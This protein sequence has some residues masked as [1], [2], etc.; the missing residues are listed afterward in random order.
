MASVG[1]PYRGCAVVRR[2]VFHWHACTARP[3]FSIPSRN[4]GEIL[5]ELRLIGAC[6]VTWAAELS[7]ERHGRPS[8]GQAMLSQVRLA[9]PGCRKGYRRPARSRPP[10]GR[11]KGR[12][13]REM[14]RA[15]QA[16][17]EIGFVVARDRL[18]AAEDES[19]G[20]CVLLAEPHGQHLV[21]AHAPTEHATLL[22]ACAAGEDIPRLPRVNANARGILVEETRDHGSASPLEQ[23][24][25]A[26]S[27][28]SSSTPP[29]RQPLAH[30]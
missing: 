1:R 7:S 17:E 3:R 18:F 26:A 20:L 15:A 8:R 19:L 6:C 22:Q 11:A 16:I 5:V 9:P 12:R 2:N 28:C 21:H 13:A 23:V 27:S 14:W 30:Q 29:H 10:S 4:A 24:P 25:G